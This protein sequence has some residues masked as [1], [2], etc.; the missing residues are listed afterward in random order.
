MIRLAIKM[1]IGNTTKFLGLVG[2]VTLTTFLTLH[3]QAIFAGVM[4]RTF[5]LIQDIPQ[6]QVW[7]MDPAVETIDETIGM[8]S[9][10][11]DRVKSVDGV[12]WASRLYLGQ[13][14]ARLPG[15]RFRG[16]TVIGVDDSTFIG[17]PNDAH[18]TARD[19]LRRPDAVIADARTGALLLRPS[20]GRG[21][22]IDILP[23]SSDVSRPLMVGDE[24]VINDSR[25]VVVGFTH[26][27]PRF[28]AKGTLFTT[29]SRA[30][31]LAPRERN[32]LSY[33]LVRC[34]PGERPEEVARR[35]E[36]STR[37]RARTDDEFAIDTVRYII[38]TTDIIGQVGLMTMI[39]M[40]VGIG[41]TGLLLYMFTN[42]N[43]RYYAML[44][45]VGASR[46]TLLSMVIGQAAFAGAVGYG[47]GVGLSA[48]LGR[49]MS[50]INLPFRML[51][52]SLGVSAVM[53]LV[54]CVVASLLSV[55]GVFRIEP[56][57]V[58]KG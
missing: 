57:I 11:I 9:S 20:A 1:L 6:A 46:R 54:V 10:A 2:G 26:I 33:V 19:L 56:G 40:S 47:L 41:V 36:A 39:A 30:V 50:V 37:L 48:V 55:R 34:M 18:D 32:L 35:I 23:S 29:Y 58:F 22:G 3:F 7:V 44:M 51:P 49:L 52:I 14:R 25:V 24:L 21:W 38:R 15:G 31:R 43:I 45:A 4:T 28:L 27:R 12:A 53:V 16:V 42:D 5:A 13:L 8:E 17:V